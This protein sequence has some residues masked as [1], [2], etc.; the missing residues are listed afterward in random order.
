MSARPQNE[1]QKC[2][3]PPMSVL[4]GMSFFLT[5]RPVSTSTVRQLEVKSKP[6]PPRLRLEQQQSDFL[7]DVL[8]QIRMQDVLTGWAGYP[9]DIHWINRCTELF[10][11]G[12]TV[13][14][15]K[16]FQTSALP[17]SREPGESEY[18]VPTRSAHL[19]IWKQ[20]YLEHDPTQM[21]CI[22]H[23]YHG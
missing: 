13:I 8:G 7:V 3:P 16:Y 2:C 14:N 9:Q 18:L 22:H 20:N 10:S 1:C 23:Y 21:Q 4:P 11:Q 12:Q 5:S 15:P 6:K 19:R 17:T